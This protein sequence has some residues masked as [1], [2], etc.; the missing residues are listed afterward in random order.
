MGEAGDVDRRDRLKPG[1]FGRACSLLLLVPF[2]GP[3]L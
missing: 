3:A 2:Q 1:R